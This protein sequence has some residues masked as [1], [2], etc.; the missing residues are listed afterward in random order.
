MNV[1]SYNNFIY[2]IVH[3]HTNQQAD[4][5]VTWKR[6][7]TNNPTEPSLQIGKELWLFWYGDE[8]A[9]LSKLISTDLK[10]NNNAVVIIH[11]K[12]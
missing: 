6:T 5:L 8:P 3:W 9:T 11:C 7:C 12:S 4:L 2:K 1:Y 10:G